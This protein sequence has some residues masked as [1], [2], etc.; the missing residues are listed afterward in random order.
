MA[1]IDESLFNGLCVFCR[2]E[3]RR[4]YFEEVSEFRPDETVI[5]SSSQAMDE[6]G[7]ETTT[8]D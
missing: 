8:T 1:Q 7:A 5:S 3:E 6:D 2:L 4:N